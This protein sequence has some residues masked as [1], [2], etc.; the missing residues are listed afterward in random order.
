MI[1]R[2]GSG[3]NMRSYVKPTVT[4]SGSL[5]EL[6]QSNI[7]KS[8]GGTDVVYYTDGSSEV[9]PGTYISSS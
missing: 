1:P 6:T 2:L 9:I 7:Y 5:H 4:K 3:D 8:K